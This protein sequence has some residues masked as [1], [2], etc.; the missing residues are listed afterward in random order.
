MA[1][2]GLMLYI[3]LMPF[4]SALAPSEWLPLPL[5]LLTIAAPAILLRVDGP[6]LQQVLRT[7]AGFW[8]AWL[9]GGLGMLFSPI[10]LGSKNLNYAAAMLVS[11]LMFLVVVRAWFH[12]QA[13]TFALVV[14]GAHLC[15][16]V[17]S[18]AVLVEFY[19]A[20]FYGVFLAD[21]IYYAHD[22]L[23]IANLVNSDFKRPR[24]FAAEPGFTALCFESLWP[25]A[26]AS[27]R[28]HPL[29]HVLYASGFLVLGSAASLV[30]LIV[31]CSVVWLVR[32]RDLRA[33]LRAL[34]AAAVLAPLV[35]STGAGEEIV[36]SVLGRKLD[37][38]T[39]TSEGGDSAVTVLDRI[40]TYDAGLSLIEAYPGGVGW[41][42]LGQAFVT[43]SVLPEVGLL[44]G[45]GMLSLYLDVGVAA[46]IAGLMAFLYFLGR[47]VHAVLRS[48]HPWAGYVGVS[49]I[50][51]CTHHALVTE[52]QY[53]FLWF[54]LALTDRV[55]A[56]PMTR[57]IST[58]GYSKSPN[59][60]VQRV[61]T[62]TTAIDA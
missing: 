38:T 32:R 11:Y 4:M 40:T 25:V 44:R 6:S 12:H 42:T 35:A 27:S 20:S 13:I 29:R 46:G 37:L 43:N 41:G 53:P 62:G 39:A 16:T 58:M 36:W 23:S 56:V 47:R 8:V 21:V 24:G 55:C 14:R 19:T 9:L 50:A 17:L 48:P 1:R 2:D 33:L 10:P 22:D 31:G 49:L 57:H 45:S 3:A 54:V 15:L 61:A 51:L 18:I 60:G 52:L 59:G 30:S 7:D 5:L 34:I 28:K 26:L